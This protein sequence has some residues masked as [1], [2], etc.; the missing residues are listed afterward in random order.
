MI[1]QSMKKQLFIIVCLCVA[2]YVQ[3]TVFYTP[4]QQAQQILADLYTTIG[5]TNIAQPSIEIRNTTTHVAA[6]DPISNTIILEN[7]AIVA[8]ETM[9]NPKN[10]LAFLI[11]HEL[12]HAFQT[13]HKEQSNFLAYNKSLIS[14]TRMEQTADVQGAFMAYLAGYQITNIPNLIDVLYKLYQLDGQSI[15][16]Y[17]SKKERKNTAFTVQ[18]EV[19]RL[20]KIFEIGNYLM[21]AEEYYAA[22]CAYKEMLKYYQGREIYNNLGVA[23]AL[24][25]L[26]FSAENV[27]EFV[28]PIEFDTESRLKKKKPA[29]GGKDLSLTDKAER[30]KHLNFALTYFKYAKT[31]DKNYIVADI[32]ALCILDL[33]DNY[34]AAMQFYTKNQLDQASTYQKYPK[35][36]ERA[37]LVQAIIQTK[38]A[39]QHHQSTEIQTY[40]AIFDQLK[41]SR[42]PDIAENAVLNAAI[43]LEKP[44]AAPKKTTYI[45]PKPTNTTLF[46]VDDCAIQTST[47]PSG[48]TQVAVLRLGQPVFYFEI[49]KEPAALKNDCTHCYVTRN[50]LMLCKNSQRI[51]KMNAAGKVTE[52]VQFGKIEVR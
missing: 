33:Q 36:K 16:N 7:Q 47:E 48:D 32:N 2:C 15:P 52:W 10:A 44:I 34:E 51:Y 6:Y 9:P 40:Q 20:V 31:Y 5:N 19:E 28:Y 43:L 29:A 25:A 50:D 37:S 39:K 1:A 49:N 8:C 4:T 46:E 12:T 45:F 42:Y 11:G 3:A 14:N 38:H 18:Q 22:T 26:N 24:Y 35:E 27:D 13:H 21:L 30:A 17:P 23:H 41:T